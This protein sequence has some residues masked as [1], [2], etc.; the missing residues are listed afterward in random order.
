VLTQLGRSF[1]ARVA[2]SL[3][4]AVELP[5]LAVTNADD[6]EAQAVRLAEDRN[7]LAAIRAH[8]NDKRL[9]L[10]LFDNK[11][12]S[13]ELGDLLARMMQ[14]WS[15]GLPVEQLPAAQG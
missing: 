15:Q 6:Y 2:A 10:P 1:S 8:L 7:A 5:Q 12:F 13:T 11:R 3:L 9:A 14:R 4:A